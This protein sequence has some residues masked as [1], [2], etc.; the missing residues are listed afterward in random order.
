MFALGII[1]LPLVVAIVVSGWEGDVRVTNSPSFSGFAQIVLD[2]SRNVHVVWVDER[3]GN[4]EIYYKKLGFDGEGLTSDIRLTSDSSVS[5]FPS[6]SVA[7]NF[8]NIVWTDERDGNTEIYY[9]KLDNNGNTVVDD[10][11][12]TNNA[13]DSTLPSVVSD[14]NGNLHVVWIDTR[15]GNSEI[16]YKKLNNNGAAITGDIRLTSNSA[17]SWFPVVAVDTTN[18]IH[19]VWTDDRDGNSEIYYKKLNNTGATVVDDTRITSDAGDSSYPSITSDSSNNLHVAW[20]DDR[21]GNAEI[22]YKKLDSSGTGITVDIRLTS[23]VSVSW[24]PAIASNRNG[25]HVAWMDGRDNN[26]EIYYTALDNNGNTITDDTRLTFNAADSDLPAVISDAFNVVRIMW[27]DYRDSNSEIY[28]KRTIAVT[29]IEIR[30]LYLSNV[31]NLTVGSKIIIS[32]DLTNSGNSTVNNVSVLI[33][34]NSTQEPNINFTVPRINAGQ[35]INM[36]MNWNYTNSGTY[37]V[38]VIADRNNLIHEINEANNQQNL[39]INIQPPASKSIRPITKRP[40]IQ[41]IE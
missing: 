2:T 39:I 36:F 33:D 34:K 3:D 30:N 28:Y 41:I 29:D 4:A 20:L 35:K 19:V 24:F 5:W 27:N 14:N 18:N 9:T 11:R 40:A 25:I 13:A 31:S 1:L 37:N 38:K 15:D 23:D 16:Y 32:F 8:I 10:L 6:V 12:I 22:Y 17:I 21:D 7:D 26:L